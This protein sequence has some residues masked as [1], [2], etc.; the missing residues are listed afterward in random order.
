MERGIEITWRSRPGS[1]QSLDG[2]P[3]CKLPVLL[4]ILC[5]LHLI[6]TLWRDGSF[7]LKDFFSMT[8]LSGGEK[9]KRV[10]L[11]CSKNMPITQSKWKKK[12]HLVQQQRKALNVS[13]ALLACTIQT[14]ER[15]TR[16]TTLHISELDA[17][18]YWGRR[19]PRATVGVCQIY[20]CERQECTGCHFSAVPYVK[21]TYST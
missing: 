12:V 18:H 8:K 15:S 19:N 2:W 5:I 21:F 9:K 10:C 11:V 6:R 3:F 16:D 7:H 17:F 1:L 14:F 20:Y 13:V 4:C